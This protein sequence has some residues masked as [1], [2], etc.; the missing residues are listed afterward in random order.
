MAIDWEDVEK[1]YGK[2][3]KDWA[4]EGKYKV[5]VIDLEVKQVGSNGN[6]VEKFI[7]EETP[8]LKFPTAD[9]WISKK[10][11]AWRAHHQ[12]NLLVFFG[13]SESNAR[14]AVEKVEAKDFDEAA[15]TYGTYLKKLINKH[16]EVEIMVVQDGKF[17]RADFTDRSVSMLRI[18]GKPA[19][20]D[21]ISL[22]AEELDIEDIPF[23]SEP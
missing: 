1:T 5:K 3:Y 9:H 15:K 13:A 11:P 17:S 23:N 6:Y 14:D 20:D 19:A 22:E 4:E 18:S 7:F 2:K 8:D 10:N 21:S 12:K 16:P